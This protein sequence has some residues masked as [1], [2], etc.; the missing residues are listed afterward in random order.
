MMC[1]LAGPA[2][3]VMAYIKLFAHLYE[4]S[5]H[6]IGKLY[7][8]LARIAGGLDHFQSMFV[9]SRDQPDV[10]AAQ[11]M[12][13][14]NG[15]GGDRLICMADMRTTVGIAYRCGDIKGFRHGELS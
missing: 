8:R 15:I 6:F 11:S 4:I 5:R 14:G 9:G 7:G 12:E 2:K 3:S 13:S 1:G 10:A